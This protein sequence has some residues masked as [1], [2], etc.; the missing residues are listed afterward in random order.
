MKRKAKL[1]ALNAAF[2]YLCKTGNW[3]PYVKAFKALYG[4][5]PVYLP[6]H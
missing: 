1:A 4:F 5:Y 6:Q 3:K 2:M